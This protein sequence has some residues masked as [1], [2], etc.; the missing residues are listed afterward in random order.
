MQVNLDTR[1][2]IAV[3]LLIAHL[4]VLRGGGVYLG[5]DSPKQARIWAINLNP[6]RKILGLVYMSLAVVRTTNGR[7]ADVYWTLQLR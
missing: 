3:I 5:V 2:H 7:Q 4:T 1:T 6:R